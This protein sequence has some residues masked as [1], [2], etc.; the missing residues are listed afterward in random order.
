MS[1]TESSD[2][3][4]DRVGTLLEGVRND[5][6]SASSD[7]HVQRLLRK[8]AEQAAN[9]LVK[10]H[11]READEMLV[12]TL[13]DWLPRLRIW[14][15]P[16]PDG[17]VNVFFSYKKK[18]ESIAD[19]IARQLETWSAKKLWIRRMA[20]LQ[21]GHDWR[22][23]IETMIS[24]CDWLLLLLPPPEDQRDWVLYE[25]GYFSRGR[26]LGG[27]LVCLHHPDIEVSNALGALQS[28]PAEVGPVRAFLEELFC[29]PNFLPG[30]AE[31]NS[32]LSNKLDSMA[33]EIVDQ[34]KPPG[35]S[36]KF[37]C[38]PHMGVDFA[39]AS[40]VRGWEQLSVTADSNPEC[41][42][43]FGLDPE[44]NKPSFGDWVRMLP[45]GERE[46]ITQLVDAVR[47]VGEGRVM[48]PINA[49]FCA[50]SG[51][52]VQPR[53]CAVRR[54]KTD[55]SVKGFDILFSKAEPP[56]P[57]ATMPPELAALAITLDFAVRYRYQVLELFADRKLELGDVVDFQNHR[58]ALLQQALDDRR[59]KDRLEVRE[60]TISA[61]VG[62]DRAVIQKMY[63][64]SD[65]LWRQDGEGEMD[66]AIDN[67][68]NGDTEALE[69]LIKELLDMVQ[70]FLTV[71]SKRF[72]ELIAGN[73]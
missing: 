66:R 63:D 64:R 34:I 3:R 14:L 35:Q 16:P 59:F 10:E 13:R 27:R 72:A 45:E 49:P 67:A 42:L 69:G 51:C 29:L 43:L 11:P 19:T 46:W 15:F 31:I 2:A 48:R 40:A 8:Q 52:R 4:Q 12:S 55:R 20:V 28:V 53:I 61:F 30:L 54:S 26:G 9:W 18:D 22:A 17:R 33:Q 32:G 7:A 65:Q 47:A 58:L 39:D 62:E 37:C 1:N 24:Q 56:P 36:V 60:R 23:Q 38:G 50:P 25:A 6:E 73:P 71:T 44:V 68:K 57:T 70:S 21:V 41:K 5:I